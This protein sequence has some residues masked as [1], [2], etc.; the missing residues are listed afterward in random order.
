MATATLTNCVGYN[1]T[2]YNVKRSDISG[3]G[4]SWSF[5]VGHTST[6]LYNEKEYEAGCYQFTVPTITGSPH[7]M[8]ITFNFTLTSHGSIYAKLSTT[9]PVI[10]GVIGPWR[11]GPTSGAISSEVSYTSSQS[12]ITISVNDSASISGKTIYLYIYGKGGYGPNIGNGYYSVSGTPTA[13]ITYHIKHTLSVSAGSGSSITVYRGTTT[14]GSK[15]NLSNGATIYDNDVLT[16]TATPNANYRILT[17]TVNGSNFTSG[18]THTVSGDVTVASTAQ[19]LA[20]SIGATD[21]NIESTSTITITKYNTNYYHEVTVCFGSFGRRKVSS[22]GT[23]QY[24]TASGEITTT[25]T[26]FSS[27]SIAFNIPSSF[28]EQIPNA[29][30]GTCYITCWTYAD[31]VGGSAL[32]EAV[33]VSFTIT[34]SSSRCT[35]TISGAV[36][37]TNTVTNYLTGNT[38]VLVRYKSSAQCT[39]SAS[40]RNYATLTAKTING[41]TPTNDI[42]IVEGDDL[43][44]SNFVFSTTDSRGYSASDTK[45]PTMIQY[46]KL[47]ANPI[48][49]RTSPTSGEVALSF[50]GNYFNGD[51]GAH[52]NQLAI[53]YRY[54]KS[55]DATFGSWIQIP[56]TTI[57]KGVSTYRS[58]SDILLEDYNGDTDGFDYRESYIFE[59]LAVDGYDPFSSPTYRLST[60]SQIVTVKEGIPVFDWG[61]SD[62]RFNVPVFLGDSKFEIDRIGVGKVAQNQYTIDLASG[63]KILSGGVDKFEQLDD[64]SDEVH[65][66]Y[67]QKADLPQYI[68]GYID[69]TSP[70]TVTLTNGYADIYPQSQLPS[71]AKIFSIATISWTSQN[72]VSCTPYGLDAVRGYAIGVPGTTITGLFCRFWY[73]QEVVNT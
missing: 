64:L 31:E 62:F 30:S 5:N 58:T 37:D 21:A 10:D 40:A 55:S 3:T 72:G 14:Y 6:N 71:G 11:N 26:R 35:P 44:N 66:D 12:S 4:F 32:G 51:F 65:N 19:V 47:T 56:A 34:A 29:K 1:Y 15:G 17:L 33:E 8:S 48:F 42:L 70:R 45:T 61:K 49:Y 73:Y 52:Q 67:A 27:T 68:I 20:S 54:R 28:Y 60:V 50:S 16:I 13:T 59:F 24:I 25:E 46:V 57:T 39:I 69:D 41:S 9:P 23:W 53:A 63:W 36:I 38:G 22:S 2:G 43:Y 7:A 18:S